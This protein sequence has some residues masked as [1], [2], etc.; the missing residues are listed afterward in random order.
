MV[1][2]AMHLSRLFGVTSKEAA[3]AI[4]LKG[5]ELGFGLGASFE[6][7]PVIEGK[8]TLS[9]RGALAKVLDS[10]LL[11]DMK[12]EDTT[13]ACTVW[14]KRKNGPEYKLTWTMED[15]R[16]ADLVTEAGTLKADGTKRGKGNWEK[17]PGNMLKWRAIGFV[18]DVLF[19]DVCGGMKRADEFG[20]DLDMSGNVVDTTFTVQTEP[21]VP[22]KGSAVDYV[23]QKHAATLDDLVSK[24][25]AEA[26]V[27]A[28]EGRIP[29]TDEEV[30]AVAKV[31]EA[32]NGN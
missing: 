20:A 4:M 1:A 11:E 10:G 29:A 23:Q 3:A 19:S 8:P 27:V 14:M 9:P 26:V 13:E 5:Y 30:A 25:G 28:N 21:A 12:I 16:R 6:F 2:P 32:G 18:I 31:L 7:I 17:Y 22:F 15:A 24:Y